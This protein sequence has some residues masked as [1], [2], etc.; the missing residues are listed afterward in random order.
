MTSLSKCILKGVL[1]GSTRFASSSCFG[2]GFALVGRVAG[3][4]KMD[5][6]KQV[7]QSLPSYE[8]ISNVYERNLI[9]KL[10]MITEAKKRNV[11][12][13]ITPSLIVCLL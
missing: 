5:V 6:N 9:N 4:Y 12:D 1:V 2:F 8:R 10:N 11:T 3:I 13:F 7:L